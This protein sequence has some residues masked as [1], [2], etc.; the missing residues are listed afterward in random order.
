MFCTK[1]DV[2][3]HPQCFTAYHRTNNISII[4]E[5]VN[6]YNVTNTPINPGTSASRSTAQG[7]LK[8]IIISFNITIKLLAVPHIVAGGSSYRPYYH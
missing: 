3:L 5:Q 2:H 8:S 7:H 4:A 1:C 6:I